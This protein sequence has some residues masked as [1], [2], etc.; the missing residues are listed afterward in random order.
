MSCLASG[1]LRKSLLAACLILVGCSVTPSE[2]PDSSSPVM[3]PQLEYAR[4]IPGFGGF[5]I[6]QE[7]VPTV[8][9]T[10]QGNQQKAKLAV[11]RFL[12]EN[13]LDV[14]QLVFQSANYEF[15]QLQD[16]ANVLTEVVF[17]STEIVYL[18]VDEAKNRIA[19]GVQSENAKKFVQQAGKKH[20]IPSQAIFVEV[21]DPYSSFD[22]LTDR[23]RPV[24]G[25]LRITQLEPPACTSGFNVRGV[26]KDGTTDNRPSFI[27]NSHC[28]T[29]LGLI[30]QSSSNLA[31]LVGVVID[32]PD[33]AEF[34]WP[35]SIV[36]G[37]I[38]VRCR[39]S[40]SARVLYVGRAATSA[41]A[42]IARPVV[43]NDGSFNPLVSTHRQLNG[44]F[45]ITSERATP[46]QGA[47]VDK[48]GV[49]TGW[50][51]GTVSKTCATL[52]NTSPD[53]KLLLLCQGVVSGL[54]DNG[55]SGSPV[56]T[57]NPPDYRTVELNG[58]L[59]GGDGTQY[60][61]SPMKN[62]ERELGK[63]TTFTTAPSGDAEPADLVPEPLS[64]SNSFCR[65]NEAGDIVVRVR[66]QSN[67]PVLTTTT[68]RVVFSLQ[69]ILSA[70]TPP[71][72]GGSFADVTFAIP[73]GCFSPDCSFTLSV[74]ADL[75]VEE[76]HGPET[77]NHEINNIEFGRCIG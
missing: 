57:L 58:I 27:I 34:P 3:D 26:E 24:V 73:S 62:I 33:E 2:K 51:R 30:F 64:G 14:S 28:T 25:G 36:C 9:L 4:Q 67:Q 75:E 53:P 72:P 70:E 38:T 13:N 21:V 59:W 50:T 48:V 37:S 35:L 43:V 55:D 76:S 49:F 5:F 12:A 32:D 18:D 47:T 6:D 65:R 22:G 56:F 39:W 23:K 16:W 60:A 46:L 1:F 10:D 74:D 71:M 42:G 8:S 20:K 40:D 11:A 31:G 52:V 19:I 54:A 69:D 44:L 29:N 17:S 41:L 7:G 66:N 45:R 15:R 61:Y 68:T 77:D 63:L